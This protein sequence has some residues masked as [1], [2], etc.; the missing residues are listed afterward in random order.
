MF[1][2]EVVAGLIV[3]S[4]FIMEVVVGLIVFYMFTMEVVVGL[5]MLLTWFIIE[6]GGV[7]SFV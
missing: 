4:R 2:L 5:V 7:N 6:T 1:L 3:L